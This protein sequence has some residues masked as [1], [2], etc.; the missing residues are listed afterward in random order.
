[1]AVPY[2]HQYANMYRT[3]Q[4]PYASPVRQDGIWNK[5]SDSVQPLS[6]FLP[7]GANLKGSNPTEARWASQAKWKIANP[8]PYVVSTAP[9]VQQ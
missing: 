8:P 3:P 6:N 2:A 7:K 9:P 1:M 4:T 5:P